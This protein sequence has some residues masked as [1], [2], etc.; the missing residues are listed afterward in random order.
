LPGQGQ[1]WVR[2]Y[3]KDAAGNWSA[4]SAARTF[5]AN[6]QSTPLDNGFISTT[7]TVSVARPKFTWAATT[8][9][10]G[11]QVTVAADPDFSFLMY[12]S[13]V[14]G[15]TV[16]NHTIPATDAGL[17]WGTYYWRVDIIGKPNVSPVYRLLNV[18][19]PLPTAPVCT[20][21]TVTSVPVLSW[22]TPNYAYT[23]LTFHV[24]I[25]NNSNFVSPEIDDTAVG[26]S[27][28]PPILADGVWYARV[29]AV[30]DY[31]GTGGWCAVRTF[32]V[33]TV[34]PDAPI[35]TT[36]ASNTSVSTVRPSL[37]STVPTGAVRRYLD[38]DVNPDFINGLYTDI[39]V[40]GAAAYTIPAAQSPLTQGQWYV[41]WQS[42][43]A[44]G[45]RSAEGPVSS[46]YV[47]LTTAPANR[48]NY[49]TA[50]TVKPAFAW[51]ASGIGGI[52]TVE[53]STDA[54]FNSVFWSTTTSALSVP[55]AQAPVLG[56]GQY[57]WRVR[58]AYGNPPY[59]PFSFSVTP[60][61]PAA[62]VVTSPPNAT[63]VPFS[64]F[65]T[66]TYNLVVTA[67]NYEYQCI[68]TATNAIFDSAT[69]SMT[70]FQML[71]FGS[72]GA[73]KCQVRA[74]NQYGAA[75]PWTVRN[76]IKDTVAPTAPVITTPTQ[77]QK[78]TLSKPT[79]AVTAVPTAVRYNWTLSQ[80]ADLSNAWTWQ[81]TTVSGT[82]PALLPASTW[83]LQVTAQDSAGNVSNP[84]ALRVF[85]ITSA[86]PQ[87]NRFG[88]TNATLSWTPIN[89][90]TAFEVQVSTITTFTGTLSYSSNSISGTGTQVVTSTLRSGVYY[91]RVRARKADG[92][93]WSA[94]STTKTI[95]VE[96]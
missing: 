1:F 92:M 8:G 80:N 51:A 73:F 28:Y 26:A 46:F 29:Q 94:W 54:D 76:F 48:F 57:W 84:S 50:T 25:D 44:A 9:A 4:P 39:T 90:A 87:L 42:E 93:S 16:T 7:A 41:R 91:W 19:P 20:I 36:P 95:V 53:L 35:A 88:G 75:G 55:A 32:T 5:T 68:Q 77:N 66:M 15:S 82:S 2:V 17:N 38:M 11:Y 22:T 24:Q 3:A 30:N 33:D 45:N 79:I 71:G 31:M 49:V 78:V 43:D 21:P 62:P 96:G 58:D 12:Q 69:T 67:V 85:S 40:S 64:G 18:S 61:V 83:Y 52:Y 70:E 59:N 74:I 63:A 89:W 27:P 56:Y 65:I 6:I 47:N 34:A 10:T 60:N 37:N 86:V 14:L 72:D 23:G 81:T 13:P